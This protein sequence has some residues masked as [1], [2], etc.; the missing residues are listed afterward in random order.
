MCSSE[1]A[2]Q[3]HGLLLDRPFARNQLVLNVLY[4]VRLSSSLLEHEFENVK[5][6]SKS[7]F[8]DEMESDDVNGAPAQTEIWLA[9]KRFCSHFGHK[10]VLN[11]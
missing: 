4:Y 10:Y 3:Y 11:L 2:K 5:M 9:E 6:S 7:Q 8:V 1:K